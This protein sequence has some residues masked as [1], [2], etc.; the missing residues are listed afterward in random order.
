M[1]IPKLLIGLA[2]VTMAHQSHAQIS[3]P[4]TPTEIEARAQ[5]ADRL[6]ALVESSPHLPLAQHDL[7][8]RLPEGQELGQVSWITR[9]SI[10]HRAAQPAHL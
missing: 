3:S 6:K 4:L 5:A 8:V 10:E 7:P 1:L 9:D 2:L